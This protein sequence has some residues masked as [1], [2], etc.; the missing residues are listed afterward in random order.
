MLPLLLAP[1][2]ASASPL[3]VQSRTSGKELPVSRME[4]RTPVLPR[5][6]AEEVGELLPEAVLSR[7]TPDSVCARLPPRSQP[8]IEAW[9]Q[10]VWGEL[11]VGSGKNWKGREQTCA[12]SKDW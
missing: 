12:N 2:S 5:P 9:L 4:P 1:A 10:G 8:T 7:E 6:A 3:P 11:G